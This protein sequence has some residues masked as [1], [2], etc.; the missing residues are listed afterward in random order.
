MTHYIEVASTGL[1]VSSRPA[2][3]ARNCETFP[4]FPDDCET[5][6]LRPG[7][8]SNRLLQLAFFPGS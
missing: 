6:R 2:N 4:C 7:W 1:S 3:F 5:H 8:R